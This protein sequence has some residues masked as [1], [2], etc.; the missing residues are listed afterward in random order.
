MMFLNPSK[1]GFRFSFPGFSCII[2]MLSSYL[3]GLKFPFM[4]SETESLTPAEVKQL[5]ELYRQ[6]VT[7]Y[8]LLSKALRKLSVDEDQLLNSVDD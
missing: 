8:T 3:T 4:D 2:T 6:V 1:V 5:H 7:R